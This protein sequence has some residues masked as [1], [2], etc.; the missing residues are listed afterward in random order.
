MT[1]I[2]NEIFTESNTFQKIISNF[3]MR[4]FK[5][6]NSKHRLY[7]QIIK[8]NSQLLIGNLK[9]QSWWINDCQRKMKK[10]SLNK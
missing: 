4:L 6:E 5:E 9:N 8:N 3:L 1:E 10:L 7:C 2:N